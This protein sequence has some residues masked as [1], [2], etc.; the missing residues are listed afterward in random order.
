MVHPPI[1]LIG[2]MCAGKST[3]AALLAER[4][5]LQR[6]ELDE[7]RWGYFDDIGYDHEAAKKLHEQGDLFGLVAFWRPLEVKSIVRV[8]AEHSNCVIDFGAS[9][10]VFDDKGMLTTVKNALAALPNVILLM[11]SPDP[12]ES[13]QILNMRIPDAVPPENRAKFIALNEYF[14]RHPTNHTL[15]KITVYSKGQRPEQTCDAIIG[16]L[17]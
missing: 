14:A 4:L 2:P 1:I 15:A 3:I 9:N 17:T 12:D 7:L 16:K 11:P 10:S 6:A 8:I 5:K 13:M